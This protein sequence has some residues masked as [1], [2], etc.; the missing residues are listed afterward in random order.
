MDAR[1]LSRW[2]KV[3][4]GQ[5]DQTNSAMTLDFDCSAIDESWKLKLDNTGRGKDLSPEFKIKNLSP[6]AKTL[7]I[8]LEDTSHP[9]KDFTH[10]VIWN[11]PATE[12]VPGSIPGGKMVPT[13]GGA[14]QGMAY[15]NHRYAGPKPP[16]G[17]AHEYR[18]TVYAIDCALD[19]PPSSRKK[20]VLA[21]A[22][23]HII[24]K[25]AVIGS[26]E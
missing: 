12:H 4:C 9:I 2:P 25:G 8:T 1:R 17:K 22:A 20:K 23:G 16:K 6:E 19:A 10:W 14:R 26:F 18:F 13:L 3:P 5:E 11:I 21:E 7:I 24:Q 15:G